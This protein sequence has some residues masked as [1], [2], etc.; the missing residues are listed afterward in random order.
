MFP[1][2]MDPFSFTRQ[3]DKASPVL[4]QRC[5]LTKPLISLSW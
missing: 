3:I 2:Q 5:F 4:F 1:I